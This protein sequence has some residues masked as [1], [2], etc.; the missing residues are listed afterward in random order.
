VTVKRRIRVQKTVR[1]KPR[2]PIAT[3]LDPR[4]PAIVRAKEQLYAAGRA[5][6]AA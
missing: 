3:T 2:D 5:K 1:P 6:R 4:D